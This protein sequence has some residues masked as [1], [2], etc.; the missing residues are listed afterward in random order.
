MIV[1]CLNFKD[2]K[3]IRKADLELLENMKALEGILVIFLC[4]TSQL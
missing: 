1:N 4:Q 3:A 2:P